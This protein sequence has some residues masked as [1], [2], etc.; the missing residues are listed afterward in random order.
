MD[1]C[2]GIVGKDFVLMCADGNSGRGAIVVRSDVD[3]IYNLQGNRLLTIIGEGNDRQALADYVM[4][5]IALNYYRD[6]LQRTT[7][8]VAHWVRREVSDSLRK[9]GYQCQTLLGGCDEKPELYLIDELGSLVQ[10]NYAAHG[11]GSHFVLAL[12]DKRWHENMEFEEAKKLMDDCIAEIQRRV[13]AASSHFI[14]KACYKDKVEVIKGSVQ[15]PP[16]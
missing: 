5:N 15:F 12:L 7:S 4:R 11:V 3:K 10:E 2:V 16:Q 8:A 14:V 6:N 9:G 13:V 1:S